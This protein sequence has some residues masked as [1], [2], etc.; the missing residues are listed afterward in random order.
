M[1]IKEGC[2]LPGSLEPSPDLTGG[3]A[4]TRAVAL[5]APWQG[6]S[7]FQNHVGVLLKVRIPAIRCPLP[8]VEELAEGLETGLIISTLNAPSNSETKPHWEKMLFWVFT[9]VSLGSKYPGFNQG[10]SIL[11]SFIS[12]FCV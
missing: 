12:R 2:H 10:G 1:E 4:T 5:R 11:T 7:D 6:V 9:E 3:P 8:V